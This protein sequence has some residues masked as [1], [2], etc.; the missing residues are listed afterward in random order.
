MRRFGALIALAAL[1][2]LSACDSYPRD[3]AGTR[4]RVVESRT[5]RVGYAPMPARERILAQRF[6]SRLAAA[7]GARLAPARNGTDEALFAALE[8][9]ELDL[10]LTEVAQDSPWLS[11]VA[12]IEPLTTRRLGKR[13]LGLSPVARNGENRWVMLLEAQV[14]AM[15]GA[16]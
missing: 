13:E 11:E 9:A 6:A 15:C 1:A 4:D 10:V 14:R 8:T 7:T 12:V 16:S 3:I 2:V 5:L